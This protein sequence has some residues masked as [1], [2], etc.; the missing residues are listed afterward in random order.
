M[1][2]NIVKKE[3]TILSMTL[4]ASLLFIGT[5]CSDEEETQSL[6]YS[7][8]ISGNTIV[9]TTEKDAMR[10]I[11]YM[12]NDC[13]MKPEYVRRADD[14]FAFHDQNNCKRVYEEMIQYQKENL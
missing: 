9:V 5:S 2:N 6:D 13:V 7:W 10:L 11:E 8:N 4:L 1:M 3:L 14:F 12:R